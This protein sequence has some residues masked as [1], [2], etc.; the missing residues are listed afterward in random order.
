NLFAK[1][2]AASDPDDDFESSD[3]ADTQANGDSSNNPDLRTHGDSPSQGDGPKPVDA[4]DPG[5]P[6]AERSNEPTKRRKRMIVWLKR[7]LVILVVA[8]VVTPILFFVKSELKIRGK[9]NVLPVHNADVRA[10][11]EGIIEEIYVD[12]GDE[13]KAGDMVVRLSDRELR[14]ELRK[15][16]AEIAQNQAKLKLLEAGPVQEEIEVAKASVARAEE[17]LTF[18]SNRLVRD[19]ALF[20]QNLLSAKDFEDT[21]ERAA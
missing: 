8:G 15:T 1:T 20:E 10:E 17:S 2:S 16:E 21:R 18:G 6:S 13:V 4:R 7:A 11:I 12:E 9:F 14:A 3:D 5:A 19:R